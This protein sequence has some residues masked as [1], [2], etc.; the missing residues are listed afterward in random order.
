MA[1]GTRRFIAAVT[2][3]CHCILSWARTSQFPSRAPTSGRSFLIL[4]SQRRLGLP[5]GLLLPLR[6][7]DYVCPNIFVSSTYFVSYL[8]HM[9]STYFLPLTVSF[10]FIW[11]SLP[12]V[13]WIFKVNAEILESSQ[14]K[15]NK[16]MI[17]QSHFIL[18]LVYHYE[19]LY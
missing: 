4:S 11:I 6:G 15:L 17:F 7:C 13:S 5:N 19:C 3:V 1:Y 12:C 16:P 8:L 2:K 18:T 10:P 9:V 14:N